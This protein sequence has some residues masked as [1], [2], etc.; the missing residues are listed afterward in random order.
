LVHRPGGS[1]IQRFQG[2]EGL[3]RL[4]VAVRS[5]QLVV[6]H[7]EI[8]AQL[9]GAGALHQL[10]IGEI[11]LSQG[12]TDSDLFLVICGSVSVSVNQ[13]EMAI[14][15][16]GQHVGEMAVIDPTARRSA[17]VAAIEQTVVLR[18]SGTLFSKL[19]ENHPVLWRRIALELGNRLRERSKFV[20][21]PNPRPVVFIGSSRESHPIAAVIDAGIKSPAVVTKLWTDGVFPPGPTTIESL[22]TA[23]DESDFA[24][25]VFGPDDTVLSRGIESE[26]PRDNVIL[27][28]GLFMGR[29]GRLRSWIVKP[30]GIDLKI[31]S[32]LLGI[33]P[34]EFGLAPGDDPAVAL[35]GPCAVI[36]QLVQKY[37]SY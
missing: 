22:A 19:A 17:T 8:A 12:D 4:L 13:R 18:V 21:A 31:P 29:L 16:S 15:R 5:Q 27:E 24:L 25:L 9:V 37:G 28:L 7:E 6:G 2:P 23:V 33:T 3:P 20:R 10:E 36:R 11:L 35:A 32:D 1:L 14:R 26:A 30:R 34:L